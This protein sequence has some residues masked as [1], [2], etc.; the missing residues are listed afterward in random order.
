[1]FASFVAVCFCV[2]FQLVKRFVSE[3]TVAHAFLIPLACYPFIQLECMKQKKKKNLQTHTEREHIQI[4][5]SQTTSDMF[6]ISFDRI[7][8][9]KCI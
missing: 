3:L 6:S 8:F 4:T 7:I 1:M 2:E 5:R 9:H